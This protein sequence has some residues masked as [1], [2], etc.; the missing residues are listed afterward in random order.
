MKGRWPRKLLWLWLAMLIVAP[1]GLAF[2]SR[3]SFVEPPL[4]WRA[5]YEPGQGGAMV[6][7]VVSPHDPKRLVSAGDMLG[8]GLSEDG[9]ETWQPTFGLLG[10]EMAGLTWHP[11]EPLTV[12]AGSASGPY[13]SRDGGRTWIPRRLG[14]PP[15]R[16]DGYSAMVEVVRVDPATPRRMLAF[17]GSSRRW[18]TSDTFGWVWEST[19]AGVTWRHLTTVFAA[20]SRES[21]ERGLNIL[22]ADFAAGRTG[23]AYLLAEGEGLFVSDDAGRTWS[24]AAM[25]GSPHRYAESLVVHPTEANTLYVSLGPAPPEEGEADRR[26][27]PGDVLKSRDGGATFV[28][29]S[30]GLPQVRHEQAMLTSSFR[31]MAVSPVAPEVMWVND[32]SWAGSVTYRSED[33]GAT[34]RAVA[35]RK[36][37]DEPGFEGVARVETATP[38]GHSLVGLTPCPK[39]PH[40]VYGYSQEAIVRTTDAGATWTDLTAFRPDTKAPDRWRGRGWTGWCSTAVTFNPYHEGVVILQGLDAARVWLS[41]DGLRT[42][43]Y[44]ATVPTQ[45]LGGNAAVFT[46]DGWVYATTGQFGQYSGVLRSRDGGQTFEA[47]YG[48]SHGLPATG[49]GSGVGWGIAVDPERPSRVWMVHEGRVYLSDDRGDDWMVDTSA[50]ADATW[51]VVSPRTSEMRQVYLAAASGVYR[52]ESGEW[53]SLGGPA[54]PGGGLNEGRLHVDRQGR[55]LLCRWREGD[56]GLWRWDPATVRWTKLLDEPLAYAVAADPVDPNRLVLTTA[57]HPYHD[58]ATGTGVWVSTDGGLSWAA[59]NTDLP[60]QRATAVAFDPFDRSRVVLGTMGR[61]FFVARWPASHAPAA[62]RK[63]VPAAVP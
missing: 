54:V 32:Q 3:M 24:P 53:R 45:W 42:F 59:A 60:L 12:W 11:T 26:H 28:S 27:R 10:Y 40:T 58:H 29:I 13:E 2:L 57:D 49:S 61:G 20:G 43:R 25:S 48:P 35:C 1:V 14:M 23:R 34:W 8:L 7:L 18:G 9:G 21:A 51:L 16:S 22:S 39:N 63:Y 52:W 56:A 17:G 6:S 36:P 55:V 33:G 37:A 38:A 62:T 44:P 41:D 31:A 50:P 15:V 19:D 47:L 30:A 4:H 5:V 46:P